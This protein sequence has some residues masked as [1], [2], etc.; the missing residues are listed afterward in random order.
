MTRYISTRGTT[1][2]LPFDDVLIAGLAPDGGL[3]V[4]DVWPR[5]PPD[6]PQEYPALATAIMQAFVGD[7]I[8]PEIF[9]K[10]VAQACAAFTNS[11]PAV[12]RPI[13]DELYLLELFH[14]PT[15]AFKDV[16]L[17]MLGQLFG[18]VLEE[19]NQRVTIVGATSGDTGSAAIEAFAG[20]NRAEIFILMPHGRVSE[21]QRRQMTTVD[22]PNVHVIAIEGSFDDCQRLVKML[23]AEE[24]FRQEHALAAV[25]SINWARIMAQAVY[26][27]A[28]AQ[29]LGSD[30]IRFV[31]PTGNFGN[32]YAAHVARR[33][34]LAMAPPVMASNAND[35]LTR[36][37]ETGRI[38]AQTVVP[39]L[40]P[41]M[42][43]QVPSNLERLLFELYGNDGTALAKDMR[44]LG[45]SGTLALTADRH[46]QL[47]SL[48]SACRV[49]DETTLA[50]ITAT[51]RERDIL[52]DP[53]T[54]VGLAAARAAPHKGLSVVLATAS[55]AKFP[56]AVQKATSVNPLLPKHLED[57]FQRKEQFQVLP[58]DFER[59]KSVI[60]ERNR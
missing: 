45:Q 17:Q 25:N 55:P 12:L 27:V 19:R 26:Y 21:V 3:Y 32:V 43:I 28:A 47:R 31:V 42:D 46:A 48:F 44:A 41:A 51:Y 58:N 59:L 13:G 14:G 11:D 52:I 30:N 1:A 53:H 49:D 10:L 29:K 9:S 57:L 50:T 22:A 36:L 39:T 60:T 16:A 8:K 35:V 37:S 4:P 38:D 7:T 2:T 6:L 34:G 24:A 33:M 18:H 23:F 56:E 5:L 54:A 20:S 15:L 40:S